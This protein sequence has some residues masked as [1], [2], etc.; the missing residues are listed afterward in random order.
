[1]VKMKNTNDKG[2]VMSKRNLHVALLVLII[3]LTGNSALALSVPTHKSINENIA[4]STM[5]EF[6]LDSYLKNELIF[7]DGYREVIK[8]RRVWEWIQD[9]G[10]YEDLPGTSRIFA[11]SIISIIR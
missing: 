5:N 3:Y 7:V 8:S 1:M 6:S 10:Q 11:R 9:G 4:Q 2:V